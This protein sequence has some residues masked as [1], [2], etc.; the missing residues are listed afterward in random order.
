MKL[1]PLTIRRLAVNNLKQKTF[2]SICLLAVVVILSFTLFAGSVMS[3]SLKNGMGSMEQRLGADLL[4]VPRGAKTQIE[5]VLLKGEPG[6]FY[7]SPA[8]MDALTQM[9]EVSQVTA[10]FYLTSL[11]ESCCS[12]PVQ[13]IAFDPETDFVIQPWIAQTYGGAVRD[14]Q[15]IAGSDIILEPGQTIRFF[16]QTYMAAAQLD[17]TATGLD[18][19]VFM[20]METM[21]ALVVSA[22]DAGVSFLADT[23]PEGAVSA[24]LVR[25]RDGAD[26][27]E[28]AAAVR[29]AVPNAD[30][31]ISKSMISG[32]SA[33]L[34]ALVAYI[35]VL[36]TV[37]WILSAVVMAVVFSVT[38]SERKK[39]SAVYRVLGATRRRLTGLVMIEAFFTS[40]AGGLIGTAAAAIIVLPFSTYIGSKL[41]LPY[42]QPNA[43]EI[44]A[45]LAFSLLL[46]LAVGPLASIVSAVKIS[47]AETYLTLREGEQ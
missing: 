9:A 4:V 29:T 1:P 46:S 41:Q 24:V 33:R 37:L 44:A 3:A 35:D 43:G 15:V 38:M 42:L 2:R 22:H 7:F 32:I 25:L 39:E 26:P 16:N 5:S 30:A 11:S 36:Q 34:G 6:C 47:R 14:G 13:L 31:V 21:R 28:T 27:D 12:S 19:S 8:V 10:Q 40:A 45:L 18:S 23:E 17:R 20:T